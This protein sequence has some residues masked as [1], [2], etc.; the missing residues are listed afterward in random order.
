M[1]PSGFFSQDMIIGCMF[2]LLGNVMGWYASN[3]QFVSEYWKGK[4]LLSIVLFGLP[5][6]MCFWM[7]SKYAMLAVPQLWTIRFIGAV[8]SYLAFPI[9]T[10]YYMGE[11]MF[12]TKTMICVFFA[13][14]ILAVQIF[15]D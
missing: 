15:V 1:E 3:L 9:M 12:T 10:W 14:C 6:M 11:T 4:M 5:S 8:V 7:G 13:M 2:F